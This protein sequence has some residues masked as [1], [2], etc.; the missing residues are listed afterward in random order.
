[1][2]RR[3]KIKPAIVFSPYKTPHYLATQRI[4]NPDPVMALNLLALSPIM[5]TT[6]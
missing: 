3:R 2:M 4:V 1:M 6:Y 5:L